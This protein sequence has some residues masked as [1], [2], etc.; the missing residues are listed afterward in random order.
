MR[1]LQIGVLLSSIISSVLC[2]ILVITLRK[3]FV[4]INPN[5]CPQGNTTSCLIF[6]CSL[7]YSV[8][9]NTLWA[10]TCLSVCRVFRHIVRKTITLDTTVAF[11][12]MVTF[13]YSLGCPADVNACDVG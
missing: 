10:R 5:Q 13:D 8:S 2:I 11:D 3:N 7:R 4:S 6:W 9:E 1:V 12:T